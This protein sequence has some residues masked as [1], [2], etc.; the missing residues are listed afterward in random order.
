[1]AEASYY[2]RRAARD[3]AW[4]RAQLRAAAERGGLRS[5]GQEIAVRRVQDGRIT[6]VTFF[7]EPGDRETFSAVFAFD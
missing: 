2:A 5:E 6:E 4:R 1:M 7:N 3:P